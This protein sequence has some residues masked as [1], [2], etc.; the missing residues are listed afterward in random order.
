M[1]LSASTLPSFHPLPR[2]SD[3]LGRCVGL[4]A[5]N[6]SRSRQDDTISLVCTKRLKYHKIISPPIG[7]QNT[8]YGFSHRRHVFQSD[9]AK[10]KCARPHKV[11]SYETCVHP[12][13]KKVGT[14]WG[15]YGCQIS[16]T[17]LND[18]PTDSLECIRD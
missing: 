1:T 8:V 9:L 14:F 2:E 15:G 3:R 5:A 7:L 13:E 17:H 12:G 11:D 16:R 18:F 10:K 6:V 4:S